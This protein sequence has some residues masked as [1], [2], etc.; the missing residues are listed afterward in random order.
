M[1][2]DSTTTKQIEIGYFEGAPAFVFRETVNTVLRDGIVIAET[3][4]RESYALGSDE[5]KAVLG[6]ALAGALAHVQ[7]LTA[8]IDS[9]NRTINSLMGEVQHLA[10]QVA[11][12][13]ARVAELEAAG[14]N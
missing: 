10:D 12:A 6:D 7:V 3:P 2:T 13:Q 1:L 4:H 9:D 14:T 8:Q 11:Q 5:A